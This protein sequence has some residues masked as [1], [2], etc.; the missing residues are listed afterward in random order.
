VDIDART[1]LMATHS[2]TT[3]T[4]AWMKMSAVLL[5]FVVTLNAA[6]RSDHSAAYV[7]KTTNSTEFFLFASQYEY[8]VF[9]CCFEEHI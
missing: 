4:N 8:L 3:T 5:L 7:P 1:A 9:N 6:T 2:T